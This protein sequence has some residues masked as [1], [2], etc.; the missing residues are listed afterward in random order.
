MDNG[1]KPK[2][3]YISKPPPK[4]L[5]VSYIEEEILDETLSGYEINEF[6]QYL[7]KLFGADKTNELINRYNIGTSKRY[8]GSTIFYQVDINGKI[9]TGKIIKYDNTGHRVKK[10]NNWVHSVLELQD[11]NLKQCFY[12]EHLLKEFPNMI[13]CIV[14]SEKTAII[15]SAVYKDKD[16]IWLASGGAEGINDEKVKVLRGRKVILLPDSSKD[17]RMYRKWEEKALK[18]GFDI[19]DYLEKAVT[20]EQKETGFDIADMIVQNTTSTEPQQL[21]PEEIPELVLPTK[22]NPPEPVSDND[23]PYST[24]SPVALIDSTIENPP[25]FEGKELLVKDRC[26]TSIHGDKIELV[27]VTSYGYCGN[28]EKHEQ[29]NGYCKACLLNTLHNIKINGKLQN[30]EYTQLEVL[31][32]QGK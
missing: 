18:Y 16:I 23:I 19:S 28:W 13:V 14:E 31:I 5:P 26:F 7:I 30:R 12:G 9:R 27:G 2:G 3:E 21:Q 10:H 17:R 8:G 6:V 11:F 15:A 32:L 4:P 1:I 20:A 22:S 29:A 25:I 24:P